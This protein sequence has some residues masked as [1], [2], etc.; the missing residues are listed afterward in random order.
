MK[1]NLKIVTFTFSLILSLLAWAPWL[2]DKEIHDKVLKE[3]GWKDGTNYN[4]GAFQRI[5]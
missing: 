4:S 5:K 2:N 1:R 3:R